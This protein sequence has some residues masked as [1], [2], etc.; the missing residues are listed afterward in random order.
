MAVYFL[1]E[2][3]QKISE[4]ELDKN[5]LISLLDNDKMREINRRFSQTTNNKL[6][7]AYH[8]FLYVLLKKYATYFDDDLAFFQTLSSLLEIN[9]F[10]DLLVDCF[11]SN[12]AKVANQLETKKEVK[13]IAFITE[14]LR[15]GGVERVVSLQVPIF[16][17]IGKQVIV[18]NETK[19]DNEYNLPS[20]ARRYVVGLGPER[21][22]QLRKILCEHNIDTVI[23][24]DYWREISFKTIVWSKLHGYN[25]IAEEHNFF[26]CPTY[27][28]ATWRYSTRL[29]AYKCVSLLT[30][31]NQMDEKLWHA[32]GVKQARY[33]PNPSTFETVSTTPS[34]QERKD[35]VLLISRLCRD[36]GI[37]FVPQ[38]IAEVSKKNPS[39]RFVLCGW[40]MS[41]VDKQEFEKEIAKLGIE[42]KIDKVGY[43]ST[44]EIKQYL[45][46]AKCLILPS[47]HEGSPM[48]LLEA[49]AYGLPAVIY[50]MNYL[51][52]AQLGVEHVKF[53]D[54]KAMADSVLNLIT[55]EIYWEKMSRDAKSE[56]HFWS[57]SNLTTEWKS[58]F[59]SVGSNSLTKVPPVR[60]E[61]ALQEFHNAM[62]FS[63]SL[64][65]ISDEDRLKIHRY[66]EINRIL[67][68]AIPK[69]SLRRSIVLKFLKKVFQIS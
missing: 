8:D 47:T 15:G 59:L 37:N 2:L 9:S 3:R 27:E 58:L 45:K 14:K 57:K 12:A 43:A 22:N 29:L 18:I 23:C 4:K 13:N 51:D 6:K 19:G 5:E 42:D 24:T 67:S 49:R 48:V 16:I 28:N 1:N 25:V 62:H 7:S 68:M 50:D 39:A 64:S 52:N 54:I 34:W 36:K 41:E 60:Y 66:D 38:I 32:S 21:Y 31:L 55:N 30:C 35:L 33:V 69:N 17:S 53:G 10:R 44:Q 26:F 40:Y 63:L 11:Y 56:L 65:T 46:T 61:D 20:S